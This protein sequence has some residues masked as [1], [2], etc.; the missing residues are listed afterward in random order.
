MRF[1]YISL[2]INNIALSCCPCG[3]AGKDSACSTGD[4]GSICGLGRPLEKG[5]EHTLQCSGLENSMDWIV[6]G[7][8]KSQARLTD[9]HIRFL[10]ISNAFSISCICA[11]LGGEDL[12]EKEMA[13]TPVFLPRKSHGRRSLVGYSLWGHKES[14][15][16]ELLSSSCNCWLWYHICVQLISY[17]CYMFA[18]TSELFLL[19]FLVSSCRFSG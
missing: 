19:N 6:H 5:N 13:T 16:T 17:L 12:L 8:A 10:L 15:T 4:L 18:F 7:V 9:F 14:D 2:C 3:L 1:W 11:L